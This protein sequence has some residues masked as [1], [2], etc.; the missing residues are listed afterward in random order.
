MDAILEAHEL[1]KQYE[2]FSIDHLS[3]NIFAGSILG[4]FGPNGAGKTTLIKLL[5]GQIMPIAGAVRVFHQ[6]Y[7]ASEKEIKDRIGYCPQEPPFFPNK[8]LVE[9]ARFAAP[10]FSKWDG[11]L[12]YGLLE[13][14]RIHPEKRFSLLSSGQKTLFSLALALAHH[15]DLLL[16]DEPA[17]GLDDAN[18]RFLIEMVRDFVAGGEK[19]V[20]V[21]SHVSDGLD[22][23]AEQVL[24]IRAGKSIMTADKVDLLANWKWIHFRDHALEPTLVAK[25]TALRHH[26]FGN[27]GLTSDFQAL[28]AGLAGA[29]AAGDAQVENARLSDVLVHLTQGG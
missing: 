13:R 9:L 25:L 11:A 4:V 14:F 24:F 7:D 15:P 2:G 18:R 5:A 16:L 1:C 29:M 21:S 28:C 27:S 26:P 17:S 22:E 20:L 10:F 8:S 3:L 6:D 23:L 19:A 12:F